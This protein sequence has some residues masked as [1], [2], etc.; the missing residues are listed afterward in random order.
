[1][2]VFLAF[3]GVAG[4]L[5]AGTLDEPPVRD[6]VSLAAVTLSRIVPGPAA[7]DLE[8]ALLPEKENQLPN[9]VRLYLKPSKQLNS[10]TL[11]VQKAAQVVRRKVAPGAKQA[12]DLRDV[13]KLV[14][15]VDA[16]IAENL[17]ED[18]ALD[19]G[20]RP[21]TDWRLAWPMASAILTRG[22]AEAAGREIVRVAMLRSLKVPA[23]TCFAGGRLRTQY[24]QPVKPLPGAVLPK[25]VAK[26][27][28]KGK[29]KKG[30]KA[31]Y[32]GPVLGRWMLAGTLA[33]GETIDAYSLDQGT[34]A[35]LKW[36]PA[37]ELAVKVESFERVY[38]SQD[39][40]VDAR[41]AYG[42]ALRDGR[43]MPGHGGAA[44][45]AS[46]QSL[47]SNAF[48]F[49]LTVWRVRLTTDGSMAP[50]EPVDL[51]SPYQPHLASW[52]REAAP[53]LREMEVEKDGAGLWSDRPERMKLRQGKATDE[54]AS[55]PPALGVLHYL[56]CGLRRP[57][58]VLEAALE[59]GKLKGKF[60]RADNLN[61]QAGAGLVVEAR[62]DT[63]TALTFTTQADGAFDVELPELLRQARVLHVREAGLGRVG[64]K[65]DGILLFEAPQPSVAP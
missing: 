11:P 27:P 3:L 35:L 34:L 1:M 16:Y 6:H 13:Q 51:I 4:L 50:M 47:S 55:P 25:A 61:P 52:N 5:T 46:Y 54:W 31:P 44:D 63:A 20:L 43:V 22:T 45:A 42:L 53:A 56:A 39:M 26:K 57:G 15:A 9:S 8:L 14:E 36:E 49:A 2:R 40:E 17:K 41:A 24:W 65:L 19:D 38:F 37:Q 28:V 48:V 58:N 21:A 12:K 32:T 62:S 18:A 59:A 29:S 30:Y 64:A 60:L 7:K 23:R 33:A 10:N